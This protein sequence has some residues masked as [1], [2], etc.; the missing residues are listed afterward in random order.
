LAPFGKERFDG[1]V[2]ALGVGNRPEVPQAFCKDGI[3]RRTQW[4]F[5]S[6]CAICRAA[7]AAPSVSTGL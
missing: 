7:R 6:T 3:Y 2:D 1:V 4:R 5:S